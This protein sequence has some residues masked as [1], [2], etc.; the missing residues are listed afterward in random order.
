[1]GACR[2]ALMLAPG[3]KTPETAELLNLLIQWLEQTKK[4]NAGNEGI[5][6]ETTAEALIEEYALRMF[7]HADKLDKDG[8]FNKY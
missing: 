3:Q 1:M 6:N 8:V 5:T 7:E 4:E 2:L